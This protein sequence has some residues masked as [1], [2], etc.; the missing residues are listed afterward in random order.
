M[1]RIRL[2][3]LS[4]LAQGLEV[5][6]TLASEQYYQHDFLVLPAKETLD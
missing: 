6:E 4:V 2:K 5:G 3:C 1:H